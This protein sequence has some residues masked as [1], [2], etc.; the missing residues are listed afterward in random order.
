M[1]SGELD[2]EMVEAVFEARAAMPDVRATAVLTVPDD[3]SSLDS[4]PDTE[5]PLDSPEVQAALA[6]D[7][8]LVHFIEMAH[9]D[10]D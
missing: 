8:D 9:R 2:G 10:S 4:E 7:P 6:R 3:L 1:R 5:L